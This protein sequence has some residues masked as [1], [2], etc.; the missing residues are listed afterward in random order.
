MSAPKQALVRAGTWPEDRPA[1]VA[2]AE[3]LAVLLP[4]TAATRAAYEEAGIW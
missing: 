1:E 4:F 2:I 3:M